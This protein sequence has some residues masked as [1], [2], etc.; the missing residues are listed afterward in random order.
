[1]IENPAST[2][3][4][5]TEYERG[6]LR[7]GIMLSGFKNKNEVIG[8]TSGICVKSPAPG[9]Y[10]ITAAVH[11]FPASVCDAVYHPQ[12]HFIGNH[13]NAKYQIV[14][15]NV[16]YTRYT[17]HSQI[18]YSCNEGSGTIGCIELQ[19]MKALGKAFILARLD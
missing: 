17:A 4:D 8:T 11:G 7:P 13:P 16:S 2:Y 15:S 10:F 19:R 5:D 1:V 12:V 6:E 14:L 3:T 9:K 18:S